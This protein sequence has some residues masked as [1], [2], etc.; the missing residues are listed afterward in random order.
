MSLSNSA[1][2]NPGAQGQHRTYATDASCA[3]AVV[4]LCSS[5]APREGA[6]CRWA[7][8]GSTA[9]LRE[10]PLARLNICKELCHFS[11]FKTTH[12]RPSIPIQPR[13]SFQSTQGHAT[14]WTCGLRATLC[15]D[16]MAPGTE[17]IPEKISKVNVHVHR[18]QL[19]TAELQ[20]FSDL[21]EI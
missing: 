21:L 7:V 6:S 17:K 2:S 19:I 4:Q 12:F 16:I 5:S 20:H 15:Q 9:A 13:T 10:A 18:I 14:G 8:A 1:A 11:A 3:F